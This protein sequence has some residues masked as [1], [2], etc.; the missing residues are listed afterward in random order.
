LRVQYVAA[1]L[2][3]GSVIWGCLPGGITRD[4]AVA[5]AAK[6]AGPGA[7]VIGMDF[8]AHGQLAEPGAR[9]G[10]D[11]PEE[12]IWAVTFRGS[13][14]MEC[15]PVPNS[16]VNCPDLNWARILVNARTGEVE[17]AS[18]EIR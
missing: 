3:L 15:V 13:F 7:T 17:S 14:P 5:I 12:Q 9:G 11:E 10:I 4:Q 6:H 8:G 18:Y 1:L 16:Q 2:I